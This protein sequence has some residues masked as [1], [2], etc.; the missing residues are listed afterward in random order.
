MTNSY[1]FSPAYTRITSGS[2]SSVQIVLIATSRTPASNEFTVTTTTTPNAT[3][4][5]ANAARFFRSPSFCV[6]NRK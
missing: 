3:E 5:I 6:V 1:G 2:I 4:M